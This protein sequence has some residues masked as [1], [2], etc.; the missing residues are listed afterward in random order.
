MAVVTIC[1]LDISAKGGMIC[2]VCHSID[3]IKSKGILIYDIGNAVHMYNVSN[4]VLI[5]SC[6][7]AGQEDVLR[8]APIFNQRSW[9]IKDLRRSLFP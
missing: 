3:L 7:R 1:S 9:S 4:P 8:L 2:R 6:S 5:H